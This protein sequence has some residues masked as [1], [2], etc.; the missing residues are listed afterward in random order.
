M[1]GFL[2]QTIHEVWLFSPYVICT[3]SYYESYVCLHRGTFH[4]RNL[5]SEFPGCISFLDIFR[6]GF[7]P[8]SVNSNQML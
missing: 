6:T 2:L 8:H 5:K 1:L 7:E 3:K 4:G